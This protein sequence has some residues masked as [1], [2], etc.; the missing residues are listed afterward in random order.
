MK[1]EQNSEAFENVVGGNAPT[2]EW[3][4]QPEIDDEWEP[5]Y[6]LNSQ[7]CGRCGKG[8]VLHAQQAFG[9]FERYYCDKC[10]GSWDL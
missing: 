1:Q 9:P 3:D 5:Q 4:E 8:T 6:G 10:G 7:P 2:E